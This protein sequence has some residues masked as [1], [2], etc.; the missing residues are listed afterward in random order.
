M[1]WLFHPIDSIIDSLLLFLCLQSILHF[2]GASPEKVDP[3]VRP[4]AQKLRRTAHWI[5]PLFGTELG[6]DNRR[7]ITFSD[8]SEK[9]W[10]LSFGAESAEKRTRRGFSRELF[11][12]ISL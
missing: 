5:F 4:S 9:I 7:K 12:E 3:S 10:N 6:F 1:W 8:F 11:I 2:S